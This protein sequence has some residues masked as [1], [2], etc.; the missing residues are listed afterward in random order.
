MDDAL[1]AIAES[2]ERGKYIGTRHFYDEL[3]ADTFFTVDFEAAVLQAARIQEVGVNEQGDTKYEIVGPA[4]DGRMLGVVCVLKP[5]GW[6][7][8]ITAYEVR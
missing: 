1:T 3:H 8:C 4:T 5:T 2:V 7:V 6:V